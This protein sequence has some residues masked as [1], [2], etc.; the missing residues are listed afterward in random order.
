MPRTHLIKG[1]GTHGNVPTGSLVVGSEGRASD[2]IYTMHM[3]VCGRFSAL[4]L[5]EISCG[6]GYPLCGQLTW[7]P[8]T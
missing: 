1:T 6:V 5:R 3:R 4:F 8:A 7:P 2:R